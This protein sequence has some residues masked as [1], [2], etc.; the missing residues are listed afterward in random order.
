[1]KSF[2]FAT[3]LVS[4]QAVRLVDSDKPAVSRSY[5]DKNEPFVSKMAFNNK[6]V[7]SDDFFT[8]TN[9]LAQSQEQALHWHED[10]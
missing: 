4:S 6:D 9:G 7:L 2:I 3:I 8:K 10:K 1:M 5:N